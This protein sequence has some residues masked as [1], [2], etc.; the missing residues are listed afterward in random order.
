MNKKKIW[1]SITGRTK[2]SEGKEDVIEL[3]TEGEMYRKSTS[4]YIIY[5]ETEVSG[6][7]GTTT[8]LQIDKGKMSI[9]RLGSTNSHMIFEKGRK[10]F[11]TYAT[12][13][14]D[15]TMSVYTHKLDV[16]YDNEDMPTDIHIN[17]NVEIQGLMS[18]DNEL[19][20]HVKH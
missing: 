14:G 8:T 12:P 9:I 4:D 7:E 15:M 1:I 17:Y 2:H 3:V 20:I 11:N 6:L 5:D 10:N 16:D 18:S 19:N 13:Y